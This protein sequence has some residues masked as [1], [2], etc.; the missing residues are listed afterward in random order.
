MRARS[1]CL[2]H[3]QQSGFGTPRSFAATTRDCPSCDHTGPPCRSIASE[4]TCAPVPS[5]FITYNSQDLQLRAPSLPRPGTVRRATIPAHPVDRLHPKE[6]ARPFH[7]PS[8]RTTVRICNSALLRCHDQG[9][10]V[11]RPYRPT[12]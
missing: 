9:L 11:V 2:H 12:L 8:S 4:R 3:V 7:L 10:S 1:I 5:A 6:H